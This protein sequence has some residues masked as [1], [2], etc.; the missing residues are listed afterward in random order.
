MF[1]EYTEDRMLAFRWF[2]ASPLLKEISA[3]SKSMFVKAS[4][5]GGYNIEGR[6]LV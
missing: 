2:S 4:L 5:K 3:H 1:V 6:R